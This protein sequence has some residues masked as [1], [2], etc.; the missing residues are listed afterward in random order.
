MC[1]TAQRSP[2]AA[3]GEVVFK[4]GTS[5]G[6]LGKDYEAIVSFLSRSFQ[7]KSM[8][9][10]CRNWVMVLCNIVSDRRA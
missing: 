8:D 6:R 2:G 10:Y 1:G 4:F 7:G 5:E 9:D 3:H